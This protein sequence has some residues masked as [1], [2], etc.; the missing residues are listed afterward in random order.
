MGS[1]LGRYS[2]ITAAIVAGLLVLAAVVAHLGLV[3]VTDTAWLD[4]SA[5]LVVGVILGQRATTN[6]AGK[7]ALAAHARLDAIGAPANASTEP[8]TAH[9]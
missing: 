9:R 1:P 5:G 6:G 7:V 3:V 4:T 8:V 2:D